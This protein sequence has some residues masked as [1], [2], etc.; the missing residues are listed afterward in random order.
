ME[1]DLSEIKSRIDALAEQLGAP[2]HLLPTY[3]YSE[4][5]ARPEIQLDASGYH[6]VV[7]ERGNETERHT[8]F[9][10]DEILY[11]VFDGVTFDMACTYE[12]NHRDEGQDFRRILFAYQED[13]LTQ[14]SPVWG[15]RK[16][17]DHAQVLEKYPFDDQA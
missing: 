15:E 14:L 17:Q 8:S 2:P 9:D 13:L 1:Q 16:N 7:S 3:G 10:L 4:E 6:F 5:S 11:D 12:L